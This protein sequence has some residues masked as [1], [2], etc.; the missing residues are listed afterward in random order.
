MF[1]DKLVNRR[2][3]TERVDRQARRAQDCATAHV[4]HDD[5]PVPHVDHKRMSCARVDGD[6]PRLRTDPDG[7]HAGARARVEDGDAGVVAGDQDTA[8]RRVYRDGARVRT[9]HDRPQ[10]R[11][12]AQVK[13]ADVAAARR[14]GP[15]HAAIHDEGVPAAR[16]DG[17]GPGR[18]ADVNRTRRGPGGCRSIGRAAPDQHDQQRRPR[19]HAPPSHGPLL[20]ALAPRYLLADPARR[21]G[22]GPLGDRRGK[23]VARRR[24]PAQFHLVP[25]QA[26]IGVALVARGDSHARHAPLV[27]S[28]GGWRRIALD[29]AHRRITAPPGVGLDLGGIAKG[30]AV[31][32]ALARLAALGVANALINAGGDLAVRGLPPYREAWPIAVPGRRQ[33]WTIPLHHGAIATSGIARRRWQQGS[34]PRHHLLDPRTGQPSVSG[35]WSVTVAGGTCGQ[36]EVAAKI[37]FLRGLADGADLLTTHGLAGV[38]VSADGMWRTAGGWP[39][40]G[41]APE[42]SV[43]G[44]VSDALGMG[45]DHEEGEES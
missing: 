16:V 45:G 23:V 30:L 25:G 35:L 31:D 38:L 27:G 21:G 42:I 3:G 6:G 33:C 17:Q 32:A 2:T 14:P 8:G 1:L 36:A 11:P 5:R 41:D 18:G 13:H 43:D 7:P 26:E 34:T 15:V 44:T 4:Q 19:D 9:H 29:A 40:M 28:G 10:Y 24:E 37:A 39:T 22:V 20:S 12:G